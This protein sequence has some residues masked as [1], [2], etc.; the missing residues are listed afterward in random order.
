LGLGLYISRQVVEPHGGRIWAESELGAGATF[1]V[2]LPRAPLA[3]EQKELEAAAK[4]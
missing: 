2:E 1:T 4:G 3:E